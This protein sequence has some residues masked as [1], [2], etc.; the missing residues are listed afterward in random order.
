MNTKHFVFTLIASVNFLSIT[1]SVQPVKATMVKFINPT[2]FTEISTFQTSANTKSSKNKGTP[3][4]CNGM[5][6][7]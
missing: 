3:P 7:S 6:C 4:T 2:T 1:S 5:P